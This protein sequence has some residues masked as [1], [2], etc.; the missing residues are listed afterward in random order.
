M[1]AASRL[2]IGAAL[3][4]CLA[5]GAKKGGGTGQAGEGEPCT[6]V[7]DC[8]PG[9][10][11]ED[12]VCAWPA[13]ASSDGGEDTGGGDTASDTSPPT[14]TSVDPDAD[15]AGDAEDAADAADVPDAT[16]ATEEEPCMFLP[17]VGT[18]TPE[19]E[20]F[21]NTSAV[22]PDKVDVVAEEAR[23]IFAA[24]AESGPTDEELDIAK[25]QTLNNLDTT[26][27]EP[28]Y[29][30]GVL[31]N[32][33]LHKIKLDNQKKVKEAYASFTKEQVREIFAKYYKPERIFTAIAEPAGSGDA[34]PAGD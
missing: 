2:V 25:K 7:L 32:H 5:C 11:C 17:P 4:G 34:K 28:S 21:W 19:M 20:C 14:D 8:G 13:D 27:K 3:L 15:G 30:L 24:F 12:G 22:A 6:S 29:W 26:M 18:F 1:N 16:D 10:G 31:A 9:L 33:D 23:K